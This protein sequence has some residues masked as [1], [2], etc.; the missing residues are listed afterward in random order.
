[1]DRHAI[2]R[3]NQAEHLFQLF[4]AGMPGNVDA[5]VD[6]LVDDLRSAPIEVVDRLRDGLLVTRHRA[7]A[8]DDRVLLLDLYEGMVPHRHSA[9][10]RAGL[11]L[12]ARCEQHDLVGPKAW[13]LAQLDPDLPGHAEIAKI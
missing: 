10:D 12:A 1:M 11:A 3:S 5:A 2:L 7:G 6:G 8:V 4:A 9:E 13:Q